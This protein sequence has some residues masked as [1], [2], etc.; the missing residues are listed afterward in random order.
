MRVDVADDAAQIGLKKQTKGGFA[1][2][3]EVLQKKFEA[4]SV[5]AGIQHR[6]DMP[7]GPM[8]HVRTYR[9]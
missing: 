2:G 9:D 7:S 5:L 4:L 8:A 1:C 6:C 3:S